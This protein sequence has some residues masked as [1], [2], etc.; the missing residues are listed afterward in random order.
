MSVNKLEERKHWKKQRFG[1]IDEKILV[2]I[3]DVDEIIWPDLTKEYQIEDNKFVLKLIPDIEESAERIAEIYQNAIDEI[4]GNSE[5]QWHHNPEEIRERVKS[6][7]YNITGCYLDGILIGITSLHIIR[8]QRIMHWIWG[9]IDPAYRGKGIWPYV[10]EYNDIIT[11]MSGAQM[12]ILW[13][14]TTHKYSQMAVENVGFNPVGSFIGGE[15]FGGLDNRYYR[16]NVIWY[17]KLYNQ[18]LKHLQSW[19]S[20]VLTE[21]AAKLVT[22]VKELWNGEVVTKDVEPGMIVGGV[23][24]KPIRRRGAKLNKECCVVDE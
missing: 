16:Q 20:M 5:Y 12:G 2:R 6:G 10:T 7:D 9:A 21:K 24:A 13:V 11:E 14:V 18:G 8:G 1:N 4:V 3:K 17:S 23:P 15:F 19:E 22:T